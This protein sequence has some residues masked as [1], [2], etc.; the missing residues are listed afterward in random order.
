MLPPIPANLG[1]MIP[2]RQRRPGPI[3]LPPGMQRPAGDVFQGQPPPFPGGQVQGMPQRTPDLPGGY[4]ANA[5]AA[6][7]KVAAAFAQQQGQQQSQQVRSQGMPQDVSEQAPYGGQQVMKSG[8]NGPIYYG[9]DQAYQLAY[10]GLMRVKRGYGVN[11]PQFRRALNAARGV[12][13][14]NVDTSTIMGNINYTPQ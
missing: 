8:P 9:T 4:A 5:G 3:N 12:L 14:P 13:G 11:S 2:R 6:M 7:Q 1:A 10:E